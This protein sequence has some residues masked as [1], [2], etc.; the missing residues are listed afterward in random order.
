MGRGLSDLQKTI[1]KLAYKNHVD[2][3]RT[4]PTYTVVVA[5]RIPPFREEVAKIRKRMKEVVD[6]RDEWDRLFDEEK[7]V[8]REAI[9]RAETRLC[10]KLAEIDATVPN[11]PLHGAPYSNDWL[12]KDFETYP[13]REEASDR[14]AQLKSHGIEAEVHGKYG[15]WADLYTHEVLIECFGFGSYRK[16]LYGGP[17]S[18]RWHD[19]DL[20]TGEY[21][22]IRATHGIFFDRAKI[23][24]DRYN[25]AQVSVSRAFAR[26]ES[27]GLVDRLYAGT[28]WNGISLTAKGL[29]V[30][31]D[32]LANIHD[33]V[34]SIS[35]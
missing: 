33:I 21:S 22:L 1:L 19:R 23:G 4:L 26:L 27:R 15:K 35:Q 8:Q 14:C 30:A 32:L 20:R 11:T 12:V 6:S 16:E 25:V 34:I 29:N 28:E 13:T 18:L 2:E 7:R 10:L 3:Q 17:A 9:E 24:E 31:R 5:E